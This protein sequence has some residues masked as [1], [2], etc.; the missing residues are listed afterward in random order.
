[1]RC[2]R[3]VRMCQSGR[4]SPSGSSA[5]RTRCT[6]PSMFVKVPSFS[7]KE[8]A[9]STTSACAAVGVRNMSCTTRNST[10]SRAACANCP[11]GKATAGLAPRTKSAFSAPRPAASSISTVF[12]PAFS[13]R[14]SPHLPANWPAAMPV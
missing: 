1:M 7:A 6:R 3:S 4:A 11:S 9:G 14:F 13:G 8:A 10:F 12:R 2:A 5:R